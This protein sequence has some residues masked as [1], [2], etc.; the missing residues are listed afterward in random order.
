MPVKNFQVTKYILNAGFKNEAS[1]GGTS[2]LIQGY[3]ACYGAD[4]TRLIVYGL[5]PNSPTPPAPVYNVVGNVGA[6]FVPFRELSHYVDLVRNENPV[7]GRLDSDHPNWMSLSTSQ[8]P[9][10]EGE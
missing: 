8:E 5:H 10:G 9:V 1:W 6:I 2:I 3:V 7:Y 4:N